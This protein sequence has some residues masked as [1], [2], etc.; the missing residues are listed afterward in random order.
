MARSYSAE[1]LRELANT[2]SDSV[3]I[4]LARVCVEANIPA[5][6]VA[7]A[8]ETSRMTIH[9]WFRGQEIRKSK[10]KLIE[11]FMDLVKKDLKD[12]ILP[13]ENHEDAKEYI[14]D[15]LGIKI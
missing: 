12:G 13:A 4:A 14:Q 6:Y 9:G 10:H 2:Q 7:V 15:M 3:G 1:F 8:L 11:V 5:S